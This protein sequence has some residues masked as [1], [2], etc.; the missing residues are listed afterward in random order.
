[1]SEKGLSW[2]Q[3]VHIR[4]DGARSMVEETRGFI[5]RVKAIAPE[6]TVSFTVK[7]LL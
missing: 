2:K 4:T 1:M 5:A 3:C 7:L 6:C